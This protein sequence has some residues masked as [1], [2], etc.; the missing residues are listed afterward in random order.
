[1]FVAAGGHATYSPTP[2]TRSP[3]PSAKTN[4]A[5]LG[6]TAMMRRAVRAGRAP[7]L[8]TD[9]SASEASLIF[10]PAGGSQDVGRA[11]GR[12]PARAQ[13]SSPSTDGIPPGR[14]APTSR[15][16]PATSD[17][18]PAGD[19]SVTASASAAAI[20]VPA[21]ARPLLTTPTA[22]HRSTSAPPPGTRAPPHTR[23][24]AR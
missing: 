14:R 7:S 22:P 6:A 10:P 16:L 12:A 15:P 23:G 5:A 21:K 18:P 24:R 19:V 13:A 20:A 4:S 8:P 9:L 2:T 1:S 3:S 11:G 17:P